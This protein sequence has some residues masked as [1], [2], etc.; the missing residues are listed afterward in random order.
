MS[1]AIQQASAILAKA[2]IMQMEVTLRAEE[3]T[4]PRHHRYLK[5]RLAHGFAHKIADRLEP[6]MDRFTNEHARFRYG[7]HEV[8][9]RAKV[10]VL[11]DEEYTNLCRYLVTAQRYQD[12]TSMT[13]IPPQIKK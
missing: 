2:E 11:T 9:Y 7:D 12:A 8:A 13:T 6:Q 3:V 5:E 4:D 10:V 1:D